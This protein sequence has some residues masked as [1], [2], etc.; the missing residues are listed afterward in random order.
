[1]YRGLQKPSL[2]ELW[3]TYKNLR[4]KV[5][6]AKAEYKDKQLRLPRNIMMLSLQL[7]FIWL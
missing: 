5:R 6:N 4:D 2:S 1:M 7:M 3:I